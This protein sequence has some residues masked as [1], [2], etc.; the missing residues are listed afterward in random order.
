MIYL[1]VLLNAGI[2]GL[3]AFQIGRSLGRDEGRAQMKRE[4][5]GEIN[6]QMAARQPKG[7]R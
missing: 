4:V 6:R 5:L 1:I 2:V 3:C 7:E